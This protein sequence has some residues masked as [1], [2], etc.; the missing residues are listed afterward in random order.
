MR[1]NCDLYIYIDVEKCLL[2]SIVFER[3]ANGVILTKG[4]EGVVL[5]QYFKRVTN[6]KGETLWPEDGI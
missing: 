5:P 4:Q 1:P 6:K 3:S 2:D